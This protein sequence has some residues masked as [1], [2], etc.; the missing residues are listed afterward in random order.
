MKLTNKHN[1]HWPPT[2]IRL[3][4]VSLALILTGCASAP[5]Q[6]TG[7]LKQRLQGNGTAIIADG[8]HYHRVVSKRSRFVVSESMAHAKVSAASVK[9]LLSSKGITINSAKQP[10]VCGSLFNSKLRSNWAAKTRESEAKKPNQWPL[11]IPAKSRS[12][13][14]IEAYKALMGIALPAITT[15]S[16]AEYTPRLLAAFTAPFMVVQ[17]EQHK[18]KINK[19]AISPA[20]LKTLRES[21]KSDTAMIVSSVQ[22]SATAGMQ[23]AEELNEGLVVP[24]LFGGSFASE[25]CGNTRFSNMHYLSLVDLNTGE[26]LWD[27]FA[28]AETPWPT[29]LSAF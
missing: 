4:L 2:K 25:T 8:C 27:K 15:E 18:N 26:I 20:E 19:N 3:L 16:K 6:M 9:A 28:R 12:A 10:F 7:A 22:V 11:I 24:C 23:F 17:M 1:K 5:L 29:I 13:A 21:L 14:E